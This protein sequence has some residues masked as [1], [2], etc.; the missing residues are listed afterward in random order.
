MIN[1]TLYS[2]INK[3]HYDH[4]NENNSGL[5]KYYINLQ[6]YKDTTLTWVISP[7]HYSTRTNP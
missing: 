6:G 2:C 7:L 1:E 5:A 4:I 3:T